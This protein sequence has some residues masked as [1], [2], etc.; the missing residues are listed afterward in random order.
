MGN[1]ISFSPVSQQDPITL[2]RL[3]WQ[4]MA[5]IIKDAHPDAAIE[6]VGHNPS[7]TVELYLDPVPPSTTAARFHIDPD[8]T[9]GYEECEVVDGDWDWSPITE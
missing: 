2:T 3:Q 1:Q 8:G 6:L 7:D 4:A 9:Y 5:D